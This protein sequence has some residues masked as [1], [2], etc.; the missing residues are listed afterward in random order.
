MEEGKEQFTVD[1]VEDSGSSESLG[2][3]DTKTNTNTNTLSKMPVVN[4]SNKTADQTKPKPKRPLVSI[5]LYSYAALGVISIVYNLHNG[6]QKFSLIQLGS[7]LISIILAT[8][9]LLK[10]ESGQISEQQINTK[11]KLGKVFLGLSLLN[12][13]F[14]IFLY[15]R[16]A[17]PSVSVCDIPGKIA[18]II[19][20]NFIG[21]MLLVFY[22]PSHKY[23]SKT[24]RVTSIILNVSYIINFIVSIIYFFGS[25]LVAIH[26]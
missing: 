25:A 15:I 2:G 17:L 10:K 13:L 8:F 20:L 6:L 5:I 19:L 23:M 14:I 12:V 26:C 22:Y 16:A 9:L 11:V 18:F 4:Q 1:S 21:F 24:I 7:P 3:V